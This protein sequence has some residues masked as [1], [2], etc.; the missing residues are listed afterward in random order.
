MKTV[1]DIKKLSFIIL[2][3]LAIYIFFQCTYIFE[4]QE[5]K[6]I[7]NHVENFHS[8]VGRYPNSLEEIGIKESEDNTVYYEKVSEDHYI[9]WFGT[10]VGESRVYDSKR[11]TWE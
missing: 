1:K 7:I 6:K 11:K 8:S 3:C 9:I 2:I 4:Y 5:A 10:T